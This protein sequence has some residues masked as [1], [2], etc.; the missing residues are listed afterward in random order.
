MLDTLQCLG[1][2]MVKNC[3]SFHKTFK[4]KYAF[5]FIY[6]DALHLTCG[7]WHDLVPPLGLNLEPLHW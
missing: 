1:Q 5:I 4:K 3:F 7:M 2:L 6:L